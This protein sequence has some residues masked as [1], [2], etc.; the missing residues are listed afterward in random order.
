MSRA[1]RILAPRSGH[2]WAA[3][4]RRALLVALMP[5]MLRSRHLVELLE[6]L[7]GADAATGGVDA[8]KVVDALRRRPTTCLYRSLAGFATLRSSGEPVRFVIG[9]RVER[10][11]LVAHAW[12]ERDG[13]PVGEP[14][15]P[16]KSFAT[17][18]AFPPPTGDDGMLEGRMEQAPSSRD[19]ILTEMKD[20][21]GVLLD[22]RTKVYF[23]LN[24]TGVAVWKLLAS[25]Q[26][27]TAR[28]LAERITADFEAPSLDAVEAD[29]AALLAELSAE[30]LFPGREEP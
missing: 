2:P 11:D 29:V 3:G 17:A 4:L 18:F 21:T 19:V 24:A 26:P 25:G 5:R 20:G 23:T 1:L 8:R 14:T 22:L 13:E 10:A 15:D 28:A 16:R 30:G 9:V 12:L 27:A 6:L 7:Q